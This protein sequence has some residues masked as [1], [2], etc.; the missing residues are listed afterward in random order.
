MRASGV[1]GP[2]SAGIVPTSRSLE[3]VSGTTIASLRPSGEAETIANIQ[4]MAAPRTR[5][6]TGVTARERPDSRSYATSVQAPSPAV[7]NQ[8]V[9]PSGEMSKSPRGVGSSSWSLRTIVVY[10]AL[11]RSMR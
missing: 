7:A 2:P 5:H 10:D 6:S 11:S 3:V 8:I 4:A 1:K 9:R